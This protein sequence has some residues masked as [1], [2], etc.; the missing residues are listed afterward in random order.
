MIQ[1]LSFNG[2]DADATY[3]VELDGTTYVVRL[4]WIEDQRA[5]GAS[6]AWFLHLYDADGRAILLSRK[7]A[8]KSPIIVSPRGPRGVL[9]AEGDPAKVQAREDLG[10]V[11][12]IMYAQADTTWGDVFG[13][14]DE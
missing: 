6:G 13:L 8:A 14:N 2:D 11:L 7:V 5:S 4:Q 3:R 12:R 1:E 9:F 10:T